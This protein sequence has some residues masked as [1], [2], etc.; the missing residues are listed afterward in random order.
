M[1]IT[2]IS[3][4]TFISLFCQ[5]KR[6]KNNDTLVATSTL[7][8][9]TLVSNTITQCKEP[10]ILRET[11]DSQTETGNIQDR[12]GAVTVPESKDVCPHQDTLMRVC[13]RNTGTNSKSS[14]WPKQEQCEQQSSI[15]LQPEVPNKYP[16]VH[17][18]IS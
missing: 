4:H 10:G 3:T 2:W 12:C 15:G 8:A 17:T 11:A 16:G 6:S 7:S 14:Q 13:Q 9:H 1:C 5:L 18:G